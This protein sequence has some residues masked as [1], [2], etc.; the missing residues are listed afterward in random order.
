M[1]DID[2]TG[3]AEHPDLD[4]LIEANDGPFLTAYWTWETETKA[5]PESIPDYFRDFTKAEIRQQIEAGKDG[6]TLG[7][8]RCEHCKFFADFAN[9]DEQRV[10]FDAGQIERAGIAAGLGSDDFRTALVLYFL[11]EEL[12][13]EAKKL[14]NGALLIQVDIQPIS[15]AL[16][17]DPD[18]DRRLYAIPGGSVIKFNK[19]LSNKWWRLVDQKMTEALDVVRSNVINVKGAVQLRFGNDDFPSFKPVVIKDGMTIMGRQ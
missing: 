19:N 3:Y 13:D 17:N 4:E 12:N 10:E 2:C 11:G 15:S 14:L 9:D 1:A 8:V 5:R 7:K 6:A 16:G 18:G